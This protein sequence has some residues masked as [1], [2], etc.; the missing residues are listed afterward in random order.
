MIMTAW[1]NTVA[2]LCVTTAEGLN[3]EDRLSIFH[4]KRDAT[5]AATSVPGVAWTSDSVAPLF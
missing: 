1:P 2:V 5:K 4:T 3:S